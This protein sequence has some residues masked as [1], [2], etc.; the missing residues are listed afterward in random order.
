MQVSQTVASGSN[1]KIH[2]RNTDHSNT[3]HELIEG[4]LIHCQPINSTHLYLHIPF[5]HHICPYC[6]FYKHKPGKMAN[7]EFVE[8]MLAEAGIFG[9]NLPALETIYFGGGTPSLLSGP[10]LIALCEG[11]SERFDTGAVSEWTLEA[12]PSTF[13]TKKA[14]TMRELG[15]NRISL[16]VQSFQPDILETL[17]RDHS[18][19]DAIQSYG[20]LRD[21]G[22]EN[23]SIDLMF[24][25]PGQTTE[26]W[27]ADLDQ[28]AAL[29][30]NHISAYNLTYEEDTDF[31]TRHESG[32]LDSDEDRDADFFYRAIDHLEAHGY[33]H[34]EISNYALPGYESKHNR[35]YWNG[36]D[37]LGLGPGAV[38][39]IG[40]HRWKTLPDTAAYIKAAASGLD[41]RTEIETLSDKD[42][43]IERIALQLRTREGIPTGLAHSPHR[44][45][46]L[47]QQGL[48]RERN[49][50]FVLT[51]EGKAL[52]DPVASELI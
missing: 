19:A 30:P 20:V 12:N 23:I 14:Q 5:C 52:A 31:L 11:I 13:D 37:Y 18:P 40:E 25:I 28:V 15:I 1:Q 50:R 33:S 46:S 2:F 43:R 48:I 16:G 45:E 27:Q 36:E 10:L 9:T 4:S 3:S 8:A 44:V 38:S 42:R 21:A 22:F 34:Y 6:G 17:G 26:L 35:A 39:T 51:R 49:G 41:T 47:I 7:R 29:G 32:E 24:S